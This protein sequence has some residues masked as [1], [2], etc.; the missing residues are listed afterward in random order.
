MYVTISE[1]LQRGPGVALL[2]KGSEGEAFMNLRGFC[3]IGSKF[4]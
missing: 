1:Q 2:V 3:C 4:L